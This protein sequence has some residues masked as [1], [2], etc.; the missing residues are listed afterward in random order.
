MH[1]SIPTDVD[2]CI[3]RWQYHVLKLIGWT[4]LK[5][6]VTWRP[7]PPIRTE[8]FLPSGAWNV[9][10]WV[11][12][13]QKSSASKR[14]GPSLGVG[15]GQH[16]GIMTACCSA[17]LNRNNKGVCC[18]CTAAQTLPPPNPT[19][20]SS[21]TS[22]GPK[23]TP[24]SL[25]S[26]ISR[27]QSA[28][29]ASLW[30]ALSDLHFICALLRPDPQNINICQSPEV[31]VSLMKLTGQGG[32]ATVSLTGH[33]STAVFPP[34]YTSPKVCAPPLRSCYN[35]GWQKFSHWVQRNCKLNTI[36]LKINPSSTGSAHFRCLSTTE[37]M[38]SVP[39]SN[40]TLP[41][42]KLSC[43]TQKSLAQQRSCREPHR[44]ASRES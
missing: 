40:P 24:D 13:W 5:N 7:A 31:E 21:F 26:R 41:A 23:S 35:L 11:S 36:L 30:A 18:H 38:A 37:H 42:E 16:S 43:F 33:V 22:V 32:G 14:P 12:S 6:A 3:C 9:G 10:S 28:L 1:P 15:V 44:I 19:S 39:S 20:L 27:A 29:W 8:A 2:Q 17:I 4:L 25:C 34:S